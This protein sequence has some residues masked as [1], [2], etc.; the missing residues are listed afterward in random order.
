MPT[1]Y[2]LIPKQ[3][4]KIRQYRDAYSLACAFLGRRISAYIVVKSDDKGDRIVDLTDLADIKDIE[5]ALL[6]G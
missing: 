3:D 4:N 6:I 5:Q 1:I 2:R